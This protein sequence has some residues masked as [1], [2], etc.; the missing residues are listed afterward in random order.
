MELGQPALRDAQEVIDRDLRAAHRVLLREDHV[1]RH[2]GELA[3]EGQI[4]RALRHDRG[5]S[6]TARRLNRALAYGMCAGTTLT[7]EAMIS[8][9]WSAMLSA[10]GST[11]ARWPRVSSSISLPVIS[12]NGFRTKSPSRRG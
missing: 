9:V 2:L 11:A 5:R 3:D 4:P 1:E 7:T 10:A 6:P 8:C 12:M